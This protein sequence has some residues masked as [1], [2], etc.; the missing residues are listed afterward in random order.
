MEC[1]FTAKAVSPSSKPLDTSVGGLDAIGQK[2]SPSSQVSKG[3]VWHSLSPTEVARLLEV[4]LEQGLTSEEVE[5]RKQAFGGNVL[6]QAPPPHP[7]IVFLRQF[8]QGLVYIL[9]ACAAISAVFRDWL[10]AGVIV[11]LVIVN[12]VIGFVQERK[13]TEALT[14]LMKRIKTRAVVRREGITEEVDSEELVPG[15]IV[16]LE[17]GAK[18]PADLRLFYT[19]DLKI[20]ESTLTGES[21]PV[22][23]SIN[24]LPP[25]LPLAD[26]T[27]MAFCS[28]LVTYGQGRGIV[29]ATGK[30]TEI[31]RIS[32]LV[33]SAEE[34]QTPLTR[35]IESF[36]RALFVIILTLAG[37]TFVVGVARGQEW[38]QMLQAAVALAVGAVPEALPA[39]L[40]ATL[41]IGV[42]RMARRHAIVRKLPAVEALGSV[43]VIC[44]DKTGTLTANRLTVQK[45]WAGNFMYEVFGSGFTPEGEI[46][47]EHP[48]APPPS[49][50]T[51][52]EECL[53]AGLLCN[54]A[55][56]Y[57]QEGQWEISGDPTEAALLVAASKLSLNQA[58]ETAAY[59]RLDTIPF[60]SSRAYSASL[61]V[62]PTTG[63]HVVYMK[64]AAEA[65]L[66]RCRTMVVASGDEVPLPHEDAQ[67][68]TEYLAGQ[69]LRVLGFA[70]QIVPST[71]QAFEHLEVQGEFTF[72]GLQ[73]MIDPPREE[74]I[75]AVATCRQAGISV[76]MITGDHALT[77]AV[78]ASRIG[79]GVPASEISLPN[80]LATASS[81]ENASAGSLPQGNAS[82]TLSFVTKSWSGPTTV[83][84]LPRVISGAEL[85]NIPDSQLQ[86]L[87]EEV[88]VFA[89][90]SP[91]QKFRLV[92]ALQSRGHVVAMTGD[93]VNDAPAL[94][95]A[96]IGVAMGLSGTEV[97]KEAADMVLTDDNFATIEAAVEEGRGV[98]DAL[99]KF[100]VWTLPTNLGDGL[101]LMAAI[102]AGVA[103]PILPLQILWINTATVALIGM[104]L[105]FEPKEP[106][107]MLR[108]PRDPRQPILTRSLVERIFLVGA[109]LLV[110][111]F[112]LFTYFARVGIEQGLSEAEAHAIARTV[113]VNFFV[114]T[115]LFYVFNCRSLRRSVLYVGFFSNPWV[116][117]GTSLMILA[118]LAYTYL[119]IMNVAFESAP[120]ALVHWAWILG[121][122]VGILPVVGFEKWLRLYWADLQEWAL[123]WFRRSPNLR[124]NS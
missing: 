29:V 98:F 56:F 72:L 64:G 14:A 11:I 77:A 5:K 37:I 101:V 96:D 103:L 8:H 55:R 1:M 95:Q 70:R 124:P 33:R 57:Q 42:V 91:E 38:V 82:T 62:V 65:V 107:I 43:T 84:S 71:M 111:A 99:T 75:R 80:P 6:P 117:V 4:D 85:E 106:D 76:K 53:R 58:Q 86:T 7:I 97:A 59:P 32:T 48:Q 16:L 51:A 26:R 115:Q 68:M 25:D 66:A 78:I 121:I 90:V 113:A 52:L 67:K 12:A 47:P 46:L 116:W 102:L 50:N 22:A 89:R 41:A 81:K 88:D 79:I 35:N 114:F 120:L 40:T 54:E 30:T 112:W 18:V 122:S 10:E 119:P 31:G 61:H 44:S 87:C 13:A 109:Y 15:D 83:F 49:E 23:K 2:D 39:A 93:G 21:V 74:A 92:K 34:I 104:V 110:G 108:R 20:D 45:I 28:T 17:A 19:R 27:N 94:K 118:Q 69:G 24:E 105:A 123:R 9:I 60:D 63:H 36:S 73:A 3:P 100:I